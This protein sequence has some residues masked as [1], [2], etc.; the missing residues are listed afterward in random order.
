MN[1]NKDIKPYNSELQPHGYW[2]GYSSN[3]SYYKLWYKC[4]FHNGK[5]IGYEEYLEYYPY[6]TSNPDKLIKTF[7]II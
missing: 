4:F 1:N 7:Y 5:Q 6:S 2:E 3:Y